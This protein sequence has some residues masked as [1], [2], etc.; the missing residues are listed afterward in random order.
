MKLTRL[1][2]AAAAGLL[3]WSLST[4][5][6]SQSPEQPD[7]AT[8]QD[9]GLQGELNRLSKQGRWGE[10]GGLISDEMVETFAVVAEKP[11]QLARGI[12]QRF[13]DVLDRVTGGYLIASPEQE[14]ELVE[15]L[16][17]A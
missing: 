4:A 16:R 5:A 6:V 17:K 14:R 13:G 10:M 9:P 3:A 7:L 12:K 11:A 15:E 1:L 2:S 8:T